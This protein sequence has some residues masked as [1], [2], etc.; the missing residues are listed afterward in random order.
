[1]KKTVIACLLACLS[2]SAFSQLNMTLLDEVNYGVD[3]N[4]I[5]AW[6]NPVDSTEY[7]LVGLRDGLSVVDLRDPTDAKEVIKIDGPSSTWRDIKTWG[8][9]AYVTNETGGGLLVVDMSG[10][11]DNIT[12]EYI[13]FDIPGWGNLTD[14]HN[15]YIDEFGYCYLAGCN[16]NGG[17]ML[18]ILDCFTTPGKPTVIYS[19]VTPYS[20]DY[21]ARDNKLYA[22]EIYEGQLGIYDVS[23]KQNITLLATQQT[24][25]NFTHNAWLNDAGDVV[26]TTDEKSNAPVAAYDISDLNDIIKLDEFKPI[27]TLGDGVIPHN[28]HVWE[29]WL[30][31]SYYTDGGIIADASRPENIIEVGNWDTFLPNTTGFDGVWGAYPFLPSGLVLLTDIGTGLYVCGANYVRACWLEGKVTNQVTSAPIFEAEVQINSSQANF[32]TSDVIGEYKTGQATPGTFDVT[33]SAV[34]YYPKTVSIDLDNGVLTTLNVQLEPYPT[35][36]VTGATIKKAD[37][38]PAPGALVFLD[39]DE[40]FTFYSDANGNFTLSNVFEGTYTLYAGGWGY[41]LEVIDNFV[42]NDQTGMVT[43]E[44]SQGYQDDFAIDLGW[45]TSGTAPRGRWERGEPN[46]TIFGNSQ[47]NPELDVQTDYGDQCYVTGNLEGGSV[48]DDDVDNGNV[49][50]TSPVMDLT[51]Y[52]NPALS[53]YTWFYNASGNNPPNDALVVRVSNGTDEV[54]LETITNSQ[55]AWRPQS[56]WVLADHIAITNNM[57]VIF[58]TSDLQNSGNLVEAAVDAFL[59]SDDDSPNASFSASETQGCAPFIVEFTDQSAGNPDS[60]AWTFLGGDPATSTEQNPT[61]TYNSPGVYSVELVVTNSNGTS[62][63]QESQLI[64]VGL[65]P[66]V[67]FDFSINGPEVT[68]SNAATNSLSYTWNFGDGSTSME[69]N[70]FHTYSAT[71]EYD[72]TLTVQNDC[73]AIALTQTVIVTSATA[74]EYLDAAAY[75]LS[76]A[77]N[78]FRSELVLGYEIKD[79]FNE[80]EVAIFNLLG[81][82]LIA[83]QLTATNGTL[84]LGQDLTQSGV[85]FVRLVVDGK[86]SKAMRVVKM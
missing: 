85:Y 51:G 5:W 40:D 50:L 72:V 78:P 43:I 31:I 26:F 11:P 39:G 77:P 52:S 60:W 41:L 84:T 70:P 14:C 82:Q 30:I 10:A 73:G 23:D 61:V 66:T 86:M 19:E 48:G 69:A 76:I 9:H 25:F 20:H 56:S 58:E 55:S 47:S 65:A 71:G 37:G 59:V 83:T 17:E 81:Q 62:T 3:A 32:A 16:L 28:V 36:S 24:P 74:A 29:D 75:Q 18:T 45:E 38:S 63:V 22:S 35:F 7:A 57:R 21:Y 2:I 33:F 67:D 34:G 1:M 15:L 13:I 80:A 64:T 27:E 6:V 4:D 42:V 44:L 12:Y 46:G 8:N 54:V 53:Y 49:V 68:F 79:K